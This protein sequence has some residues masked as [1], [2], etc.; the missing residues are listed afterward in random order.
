[1]TPTLEQ[2]LHHAPVAVITGAVSGIGAALAHRLAA[3]GYRLVLLNRS[4]ARTR[5]LLEELA[6]RFPELEPRV[7]EVDLARHE[8]I[9]AAANVV[10]RE[11]RRV[12]ALFNNAGVLRSDL[13][14][15]PHGNDLHFE[16]NTIAPYLLTTRLLPA[17]K[18][19][20]ESSGR[21]VVVTPATSALKPIR[22]LSIDQLKHGLKGGVF[23]AY[24]ASKLAWAVVN[25]DLAVQWK[26]FGVE[27]YAIDPGATRTQ[28]TGP[29]SNAPLPVRML[30]RFL[31]PPSKGAAR[32]AAPLGRAWSG[33]SGALLVRNK[34][35][36]V[37]DAVVDVSV[38]SELLETV[39]A[40]AATRGTADEDR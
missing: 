27:L 31:P 40:E 35:Y 9:G 23:G 15:S 32:L 8:S 5:P 25:A 3:D 24:A 6:Q 2:T 11:F 26:K 7:V 22:R 34:P 37:P 14:Q 12:D 18:S 33:K 13:V 39:R 20:A 10:L 19:A 1:M 38:R 16:V 28:M 30:W 36:V 4:E 21:A 17:L 29:G